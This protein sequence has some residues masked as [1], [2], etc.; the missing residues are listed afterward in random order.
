MAEQAF[1][2]CIRQCNGALVVDQQDRARRGFHHRTE[3]HLA[4][5]QA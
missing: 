3:T 2:V 1:R 5:S 4:G